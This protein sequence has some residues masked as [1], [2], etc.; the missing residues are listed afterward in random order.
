MQQ[1]F[2]VWGG[3]AP[4]GGG[5]WRRNLDGIVVIRGGTICPLICVAARQY[6]RGGKHADG[7]F[8]DTPS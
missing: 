5:N 3:E 4:P 1:G 8:G 7:R 6:I 2:G